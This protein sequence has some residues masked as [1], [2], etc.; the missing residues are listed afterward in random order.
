MDGTPRISLLV[1]FFVAMPLKY[2]A[3]WEHATLVPGWFHEVLFL[4]YVGL[5][6]GMVRAEGW[7]LSMAALGFLASLVPFGTFLF[8]TR[9]MARAS[10]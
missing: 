9:A 6:A 5:L 3:H 4:A 1:L 2:L 7:S 8:E 10:A